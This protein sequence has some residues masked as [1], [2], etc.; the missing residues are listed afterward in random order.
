MSKVT[1]IMPSLNV[2][3]YIE[4][5]LKSVMGQ[6][7]RDIEILCIDAGSVD[8]TFEII[9]KLAQ[10]DCRIK[11]IRSDKKSYGYQVNLG[12]AKAA[13][14]YVGIVETDDYIDSRMYETLYENAVAA[15]FPDIVKCGYTAYWTARD[16]ELVFK[17]RRISGDPAFYKKTV[18]PADIPFLAAEDWYLWSGIYKGSFLSE[19]DIRLSESPGAA[20]QDI[21]FLHRTNVAAESTLYTD[22][23]LYHYCIDREGA[24]SNSGKELAY[25][26]YEFQALARE[27][28]EKKAARA[29][30][31]RMAKSFVC[32]CRTFD[33]ERIADPA[34]GEQY[35]WFSDRLKEAMEEGQISADSLPPGIF[36]RLQVLLNSPDK[37]YQQYLYDQRHILG[38]VESQKYV[39]FGCGDRGL[40]AFKRLCEKQG[41]IIAFMDNNASLW[42]GHLEGIPILKPQVCAEADVNYIIA[43]E[44]HFDKI[45]EQLLEL[46]VKKEE[47]GIFW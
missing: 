24:S 27:S 40:A 17:E 38:K 14:E 5:S 33:E 39:I 36:K 41:D 30:Y 10:E 19:N 43:N 25:S 26:Y 35:G 3:A 47:I 11:V 8:G 1:V 34:F 44:A 9:E 45:K 31:I 28:W 6:T 16:G 15:G 46:G 18:K 7:L 4:K 32:C 20:F 21:G 37:V 22:D 12:I 23:C 13:G 2:A 29:M 42:E